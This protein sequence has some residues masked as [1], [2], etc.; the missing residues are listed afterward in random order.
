MKPRVMVVPAEYARY[1]YEEAAKALARAAM[2]REMRGVVKYPAYPIVL[3][4]KIDFGATGEC[5]I[6]MSQ[7]DTVWA[8]PRRHMEI[9]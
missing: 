6:T 8:F 9:A 3:D 2:D 1:V 5:I 7:P 4:S